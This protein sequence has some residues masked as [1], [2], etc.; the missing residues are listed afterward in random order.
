[1]MLKN[2]LINIC[3]IHLIDKK[4]P[5]SSQTGA[6]IIQSNTKKLIPSQNLLSL[7]LKALRDFQQYSYQRQP[8]QHP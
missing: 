6:L 3:I 8:S 1:M 4:A 7:Q 5:V 2:E